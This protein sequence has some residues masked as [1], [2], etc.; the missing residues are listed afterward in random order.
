MGGVHVLGAGLKRENCLF[1]QQDESL[2]TGIWNIM[3]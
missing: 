2:V 1:S 3:Q